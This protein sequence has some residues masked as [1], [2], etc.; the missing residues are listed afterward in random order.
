M[1]SRQ[2]KVEAVDCRPG[3]KRWQLEPGGIEMNK[4]GILGVYF[5]GRTDVICSGLCMRGEREASRSSPWLSKAFSLKKQGWMRVCCCH[6]LH[7]A[8][9][10]AS[11]KSQHS[12]LWNEQ[13]FPYH[14]KEL[15]L[16]NSN[17]ISTQLGRRWIWLLFVLLLRIILGL[18]IHESKR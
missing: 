8:C 10:K 7:S 16:E 5:G 12:F 15:L 2:A 4:V 9:R 3:K 14:D 11:D 18:H 13:K 17:S 1:V 6:S